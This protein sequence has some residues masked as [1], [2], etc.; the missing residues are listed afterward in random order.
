MAI[1]PS[2]SGFGQSVEIDLVK[3]DTGSVMRERNTNNRIV[4]GGEGSYELVNADGV[5]LA[6]GCLDDPIVNVGLDAILNTM[7]G[8]VA[9]AG[10]P[11][12]PWFMGL[13]TGGATLA[14][15]D[16]TAAVATWPEFTTYT[17]AFRPA[18]TD[19]APTTT[20]VLTNTSP[21]EFTITTGGTLEGIFIVSIT[22]K[23][24]VTGVLW[25][26]A[27]FTSAPLTVAAT[28]VLRVTYSVTSARG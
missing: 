8:N 2:S 9:S 10:L 25:S 11:V 4:F 7:F 1:E 13:I 20:Q 26:S 5:L 12:D 23:S 27:A 21:I 3:G 14:N 24:D 22:T 16:T 17:P 18:W 15:A 28:D 6:E 19:N